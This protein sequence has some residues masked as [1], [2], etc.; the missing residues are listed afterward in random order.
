MRLPKPPPS[1]PSS[2]I[3][4]CVAAAL[5]WFGICGLGTFSASAQPTSPKSKDASNS[6]FRLPDGTVVLVTK[7]PDDPQLPPDAV[8]LPA[9]DY[10]KLVDQVEKLQ[11]SRSSAKPQLPS[12][13]DIVARV[14]TTGQQP[15][16]VL[17]VDYSYKTTMP[18][19][20]VALGGKKGQPLSVK[21]D[22]GLPVLG[23]ADDGLTVLVERPG[24]YSLTVEYETAVTARGP[25]GEPGFEIGLPRAAITTLT[26]EPEPKVKNLTVGTRT[27]DRPNEI[28]RFPYRSGAALG[29]TDLLELS[30]DAETTRP[31]TE[32]PQTADSEI[33]VRVDETRI[34]TTAKIRLK[35][36]GRVWKLALP[37]NAEVGVDRASPSSSGT[38]DVSIDPVPVTIDRPEGDAEPFWTIRVPETGPAATDWV[39]TAVVRDSR[40][41]PSS[42]DYRGPYAVG[43][44]AVPSAVRHTGS[45]RVFAPASVRLRFQPSSE[46]RRQDLPNN[47]EEDLAALFR[48]TSGVG[49]ANQTPPPLMGF[50]ARPAQGFVRIEP[51]YKLNLTR[52]GWRIIAELKVTPVRSEIDQLR[53]ELPDGWDSGV[54]ASSPRR[55]SDTGPVELVDEVEPIKDGDQRSLLIRL[56]QPQKTPFEMTISA[57]FPLSTGERQAELSLPRF[58]QAVEQN[59]K[60]V[61]TVPE[62]I[63]LAGTA[64]GRDGA[65]A[66]EPV[67]LRPQAAS[68]ASSSSVSTTF[69]ASFEKSV[70]KVEL[71]WQP[72]QPELSAEVQTEVTLYDRQAVVSQVY[73]IAVTDPGMWRPIRF[74]GPTGTTGLRAN[75]PLEPIGPGEWELAAPPA[76][77]KVYQLQLSYGLPVGTARSSD[78][79]G[80]KRVD[81]KL[82]WPKAA[83]RVESTTRVWGSVGVR[84]LARFEGP[85]RELPAEPDPDRDHLPWLTLSGSGTDLPLEIELADPTHSTIPGTWVERTLYQVRLGN[86]LAWRARFLLRRWNSSGLDLMLPPNAAAVVSVD[87][88]KVDNF[89]PPL[90]QDPDWAGS[91][92]RVPLPEPKAGRRLLTLDVWYTMPTASSSFG[93]VRLEPARIANA[94]NRGAARWQLFF[95][96]G[97]VPMMFSSD[98]VPEARWTFRR[99]MF[100]P[101]AAVSTGE[102]ERWFA[103]GS[104]IGTDR[105]PAIPVPDND[106]DAALFKQTQPGTVQVYRVSRVA[107]IAVCSV[108]VMIGVVAAS[109]IRTDWLGPIIAVVGILFSLVAVFYPQPASQLAMASQPGL[110]GAA[111]L[112]LTQVGLRWYHRRQVTYLPGFTRTRQEPISGGISA[113]LP[114]QVPSGTGTA[115]KLATQELPVTAGSSRSH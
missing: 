96:G 79:A 11:Q 78:A 89:M 77:T 27:P 54:E 15:V 37:P 20:V 5:L 62:G 60:L 80:N 43:P 67:E 49:L 50:E 76:G 103:E 98:M 64:V 109:R 3:A 19:T 48:F 58:P 113:Q 70:D 73:E 92:V 94:A 40:P 83:T 71:S 68:G 53:V 101:A 44:F 29:P 10:Q 93:Q 111:I 59:T 36:S 87:G 72:Y 35:G 23:L 47:A 110:V 69:G 105:V 6:A 97:V 12:K 45:V 112:L 66:G 26:L 55:G 86:E 24:Q 33:T 90:T 65:Q 85:W 56:A 7:N 88:V 107:L 63:E 4:R 18:Q 25:S 106:P 42:E 22:Q 82:I 95:T 104:E 9:K 31:T 115:P 41:S 1:R 91:I 52:V 32:L 17:K 16:A 74:Q 51:T 84:R 13:C 30:W 14:E 21:S 39:V 114:Q 2:K 38:R 57:T 34:D 61:V 108:I 100:T 46:L 28:R 75:P 99:G 102:L 81:L 8:L